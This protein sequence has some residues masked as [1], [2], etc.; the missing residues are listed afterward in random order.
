[1]NQRLNDSQEIHSNLVR[2]ERNETVN[3]S[4]SSMEDK[5]SLPCWIAT[6]TLC[7]KHEK[8]PS[9]NTE[10]LD[11]L[12]KIIDPILEVKKSD[13]IILFPAGWL[14]TGSRDSKTIYDE[15]TNTVTKIL[16]KSPHEI[17]VCIGIDGRV[18]A[19]GFDHDQIALIINKTGRLKDIKKFC[20][21]PR[22]RKIIAADLEKL[23]DA[24]SSHLFSFKG[25][26]FFVSVCY[27]ICANKYGSKGLDLANPGCDYILNLVH[28]FPKK[29]KDQ[30]DEGSGVWYFQVH[31]FGAA[32]R[33]WN[34]PVFGT[35]IFINRDITE[36]WR[37]GVN[38]KL[39]NI[40]TK[41]KG[42][43]ADLFSINYEKIPRIIFPSEC[44]DV[45][46]EV[47]F[48]SDTRSNPDNQIVPGSPISSKKSS[49]TQKHDEFYT[50]SDFF[51]SV[52]SAFEHTNWQNI[53][54]LERKIKGETQ[55]RYIFD[56]WLIKGKSNPSIFY[57]FNDWEKPRAGLEPKPEISV[58]IE[59]WRDHFDNIGEDI[60]KNKESIA[61]KM[62]VMPKAE[63]NKTMH[64][65]WHR[66]RFLFPKYRDS[67][68]NLDPE[69]IAESMQ[70]LIEETKAA[71]DAYFV[72][73]R[74]PAHPSSENYKRNK[75]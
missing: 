57:E 24:K 35:G 46:A 55:Y 39:G 70:V 54:G 31:N 4:N 64:K 53:P 37:T 69:K 75:I 74:D 45:Y 1:M 32:S 9:K 14:H 15:L 10:R 59:F 51:K 60:Q 23:S 36:K 42:I 61:K 48:F 72:K 17:L 29:I 12:S 19:Q 52:I 40:S 30:K 56:D 5:E 38:W 62:P 47:R 13:G 11:M 67:T 43:T 18:D 21:S 22:E 50:G 2:T 3:P 68:I 8:D 28:R 63:W 34:C 6:V 65:D 71:V 7:S 20:G 33:D 16:Q 49:K 58:E 26:T 27:D 73:I 66:L 44:G 41:T 25:K